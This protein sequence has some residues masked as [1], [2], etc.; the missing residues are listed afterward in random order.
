MFKGKVI[1]Y[2]VYKRKPQTQSKVFNIKQAPEPWDID[3]F[4]QGATRSELSRRGERTCRLILKGN[5]FFLFFLTLL[6]LHFDSLYEHWI[7]GTSHKNI[8]VLFKKNYPN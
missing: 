2:T 3:E 8:S 1:N 7:P 4:A 6:L 5:A